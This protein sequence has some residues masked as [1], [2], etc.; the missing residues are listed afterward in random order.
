MND[1]S[2]HFW[3]SA[4][5][6]IVTLVIFAVIPHAYMWGYDKAIALFLGVIAGVAKELIWD[7][8]WGRGTP[9]FDDFLFSLWGAFSAMFAWAIVETIVLAIL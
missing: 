7:K 9:E 4:A 1:K 2:K 3:A 8:W 5:I 6:T